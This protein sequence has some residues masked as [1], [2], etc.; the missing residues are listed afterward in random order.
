MKQGGLD[1]YEISAFL[2]YLCSKS[3]KGKPNVHHK[4]CAMFWW[5]DFRGPKTVEF[6]LPRCYTVKHSCR[7]SPRA[8]P[9]QSWFKLLGK[10]SIASALRWQAKVS[11]IPL[12]T[13]GRHLFELLLSRA[14]CFVLVSECLGH[15]PTCQIHSISNCGIQSL[16]FSQRGIFWGPLGRDCDCGFTLCSESASI[17]RMRMDCTLPS[18]L[19]PMPPGQRILPRE[20]WATN[21]WHLLEGNRHN[22]RAL[23]LKHTNK[24]YLPATP[25]SLISDHAGNSLQS[26]PKITFTFS[27]NTVVHFGSIDLFQDVSWYYDQALSWVSWSASSMDSFTAKGTHGNAWPVSLCQGLGLQVPIFSVRPEIF[28]ALV[29]KAMARSKKQLG[30]QLPM[31]SYKL[32]ASIV[33]LIFLAAGSL[34]KNVGMLW[35]RVA[36]L[37]S[38]L[39]S[40]WRTI[41]GPWCNLHD[42]PVGGLWYDVACLGLLCVGTKVR[43]DQ[44]KRA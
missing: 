15:T 3:P 30:T 5:A 34:L 29:L 2:R 32:C 43:K 37:V 22:R 28:I 25:L 9:L 17:A 23:K 35:A 27:R 10:A 40:L 14:K 26:F 4:N 38:D 42:Q 31:R 12:W 16:D 8:R 41:P 18:W 36:F 33:P 11:G 13:Q 21:W 6:S 39:L 24:M 7:R 20:M 44:K 19:E 1:P